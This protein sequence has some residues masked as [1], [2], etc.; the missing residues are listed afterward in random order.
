MV[1]KGLSYLKEFIDST[2]EIFEPSISTKQGEKSILM[3]AYY[4]N[5]LTHVFMNEAEISC[6]LLGFSLDKDSS[7][8]GM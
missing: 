7:V 5:N 2:R 6:S 8:K 1:K 4:R 3:L